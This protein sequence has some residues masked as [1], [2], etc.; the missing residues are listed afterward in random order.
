MTSPL[1][2][3]QKKALGVSPIAKLWMKIKGVKAQLKLNGNRNLIYVDPE[4]TIQFWNRHQEKQKYVIPVAMVDEILRISP[5]GVWTVWDSELMNFK[6]K[7]I[8]DMVYLYDC[9]VWKNEWL[10]GRE[11]GDRLDIV[12]RNVGPI[13]LPD[14][15]DDAKIDRPLYVAKNYEPSEWTGV[16][17]Q[18]T[19]LWKANPETPWIEGLVAK[20]FD[21]TSRLEKGLEEYNNSSF[22]CRFRRPHKNYIS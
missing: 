4:G 15:F 12:Q 21:A 17:D 7:G 2:L 5:K 8:K 1:Y 10:V 9:L 19:A 22:M 18:L 20:R 6:T 16:W 11:Y 14:D 13:Y 3:G